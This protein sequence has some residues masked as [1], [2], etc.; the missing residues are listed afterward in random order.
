[1][2]NASLDLMLALA[3]FVCA[4]FTLATRYHTDHPFNDLLRW[5]SARHWLH[6]VHRRH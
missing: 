4:A 6:G 5:I 3:V 2:S 1:M